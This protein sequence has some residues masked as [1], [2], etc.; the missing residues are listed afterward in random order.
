MKILKP[1]LRLA[2]FLLAVA[3]GATLPVAAAD[4]K[5]AIMV[6]CTQPLGQGFAYAWVAVDAS[7]TPRAIGVSLS[8]AALIDLP[9]QERVLL[10]DLP[11]PAQRAGFNH[12]GLNWNP[13]GHEPPHVY[14]LPHFDVHFYRIPLAQQM[15]ILPEDPR[16]TAK[17]EKAPPAAQLPTGYVRAPH[18]VPMMG[19]HWVNPT[20]PEF[21]DRGFFYT[22]VFGS[23][24]G[25][26]IFVEPMVTLTQLEK[27][28]TVSAPV[29]PPAIFT[30][31][32]PAS[33][34]VTWDAIA[35]EHRI[36][37]DDLAPPKRAAPPGR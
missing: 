13:Q 9:A 6:G 25:A 33:Y 3:L 20:A 35:H 23:Y 4:E 34:S 11:P 26:M 5:L 24:D 29:P 36:S 28:T 19:A 15:A 14:D 16:Y 1:T 30:A 10:L 18:G 27:H 17:L 37:L 8:E 22:L 12:V 7:G 31:M 32:M 21:R 2:A